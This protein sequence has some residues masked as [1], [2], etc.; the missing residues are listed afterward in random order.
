[1]Y[2]TE[3]AVQWLAGRDYNSIRLTAKW[4]IAILARHPSN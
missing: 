3:N 1:M 2:S 4:R